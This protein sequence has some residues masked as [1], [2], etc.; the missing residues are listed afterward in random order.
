MNEQAEDTELYS[1]LEVADRHSIVGGLERDHATNAPEVDDAA[2]TRKVSCD[3]PSEICLAKGIKAAFDQKTAIVELAPISINKSDDGLQAV[4]EP[5]RNHKG[6]KSYVLGLSRKAEISL[7]V[8][9]V[10]VVLAAAGIGIGVGVTNRY[11]HQ[12]NLSTPLKLILNSTSSPG[13]QPSVDSASKHRILNDSSLAALTLISGERTIVFQDQ[14]GVV[15]QANYNISAGNWSMA[16]SPVIAS[17]P[18]NYTPL[19]LLHNPNTT[20]E[21]VLFVHSW[22]WY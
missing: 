21:T 2:Y 8:L 16:S 10:I 18:K 15:R 19:A 6:Q 12:D 4:D 9:L 5:E 14:E 1:T 17:G 7:L 13:S 22:Y 11:L 20:D 3:A